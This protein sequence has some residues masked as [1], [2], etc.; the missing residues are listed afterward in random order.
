MS[1]QQLYV[2]YWRL[3][4]QYQSLAVLCLWPALVLSSFMVA[5]VYIARAQASLLGLS[6]TST[7]I[8]H[9]GRKLCAGST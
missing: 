1:V 6:N 2:P 3:L 5:G 8:R 4:S 9:S 7:G